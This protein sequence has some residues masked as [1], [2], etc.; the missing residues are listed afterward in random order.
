MGIYLKEGLIN[1]L[2][3]SFLLRSVFS[4]RENPSITAKRLE[5]NLFAVLNLILRNRF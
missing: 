4:N 1:L 2:S 3:P 5:N